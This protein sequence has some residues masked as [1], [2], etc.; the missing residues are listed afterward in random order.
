MER[1]EYEQLKRL[2]LDIKILKTKQRIREYVYFYGEDNVYVSFSGGKDSTVLLD[3][4]RQEFPDIKAVFCNT[5]VEFPEIVSFVK[6]VQIFS[7]VDII[8]PKMSFKK[9]IEKYGYPVVS[10]EQA[11]YIYDYRHTKSEKLKLSR[12]NGREKDGHYKISEKW[13]Y[14]VDA[15]FEI[16]GKCCSILKKNP[17]KAYTKKT[18]R[19]KILGTTASESILRLNNYL[20]YGCN[21]FSETNPRSAPLSFWTEQDILSYISQYSLPICNIYGDIIIQ[22]DGNLKTTGE[23]RTGCVACAFGAHLE[24]NENRYQ[25]L[26]KTHPKLWEVYMDKFG[27]REVLDYINVPIYPEDCEIITEKKID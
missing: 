17:M 21:S 1:S 9:T 13:K 11:S 16:S 20:R 4:A 3:I 23:D 10:K 24:K 14:L 2:P 8:R 27:F 22:E 18:G 6:W 25:R 19:Y 26:Y 5:G 15:P 12:W 7:N